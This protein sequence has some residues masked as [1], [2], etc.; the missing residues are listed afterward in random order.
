MQIDRV[1]SRAS[2]RPVAAGVTV[3]ARGGCEQSEGRAP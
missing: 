2:Y 3:L 1:R